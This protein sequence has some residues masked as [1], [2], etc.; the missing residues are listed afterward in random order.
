MNDKT[1]QEIE[2]E[3]ESQIVAECGWRKFTRGE[4]SAVFNKVADS[5][6]WKNPIDA[7]VTLSDREQAAVAWAVEFF[8]GSRAS[9][10][11]LGTFPAHDGGT[12][13]KYRVTAAGYYK[14]IGA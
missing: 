9:L 4:L 10:E 14:T 8:T 6:N 3:S 1:I 2:A 11:T 7:I 13:T 5:Q 12:Y